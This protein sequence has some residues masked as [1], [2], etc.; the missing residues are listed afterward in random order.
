M[1]QKLFNLIPVI[2]E[3][4]EQNHPLKIER[5]FNH[6]SKIAINAGSNDLF[7]PEKFNRS[8]QSYNLN[9]DTD[10]VL[11]IVKVF[12][13]YQFLHRSDFL[14]MIACIHNFMFPD[15]LQVSWAHGSRLPQTIIYPKFKKYNILSVPNKMITDIFKDFM[16][17]YS[18]IPDIILSYLTITTINEC[19]PVEKLVNKLKTFKQGI[20]VDTYNKIWDILILYKIDSIITS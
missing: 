3:Y 19:V 11:S 5:Y 2:K 16:N 15:K 14:I 8:Y 4:E 10:N 9:Y 18:L 7:I 17:N 6:L 13:E 1:I 12:I 20:S